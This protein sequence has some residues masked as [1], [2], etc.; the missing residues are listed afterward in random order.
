MRADQGYFTLNGRQLAADP[1][2]KEKIQQAY[3]ELASTKPVGRPARFR[4]QQKKQ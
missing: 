3:V 1:A 2:Q 4:P